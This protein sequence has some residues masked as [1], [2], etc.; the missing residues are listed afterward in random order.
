M[1]TLWTFAMVT[2]S[3]C[4]TGAVDTVSMLMPRCSPPSVL[5]RLMLNCRLLLT[6][7]SFRLPHRIEFDSSWRALMIM[8][9]LLLVSL[10]S[11]CVALVGSRNWSSVVMAMGNLVQWLVKAV[12]RRRMSSAAGMRT[13][14]R[15]L[16]TMVPNVV[17]MVTLAP[18][19][20][21]LL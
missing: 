17:W 19:Q 2:L 10:V 12:R 21:I 4:G 18:L 1:S 16:L 13:V 15:P 8:L 20:F 9:M 3:A 5:P 7:I 14:I 6:T 11:A